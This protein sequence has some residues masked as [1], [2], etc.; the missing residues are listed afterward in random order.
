MSIKIMSQVWESATVGGSEL[1]VLLALADYSND[2]G[3]S[4][5]PSMKSL[6]KKARLSE[7]QTRRII[8]KLIEEGMVVLVEQGGWRNGRNRSNEYK[9]VL[10]ARGVPANCK[11]GTRVD[12]RGG[13]GAHARTVPAPMQED[14]SYNHHIQPPLESVAS[15][16]TPQQ[17]L[18]GAV[19]E[20]AGWDYKTLT[21][22]DKGRVALACGALS[23][24]GYSIE[25]L[26][27]WMVE[28]W[29]KDWRWV[30]NEQHPTPEDVRQGIGKLRSVVKDVAPVPKSKG[31]Q[32]FERLAKHIG[33]TT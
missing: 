26:R 18:F 10:D 21:E 30:K 33:V 16:P 9:L 20:A 6:S 25:D 14:P 5:Y 3:E 13:T 23:K 22:K 17:E 24:A 29:F 31:I 19:C 32:S 8:R 12:A 7:D 4:I 1:L 11:G 15:Q 27:Q 2:E 28:V